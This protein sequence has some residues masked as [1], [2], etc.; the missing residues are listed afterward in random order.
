LGIYVRNKSI[1]QK[2]IVVPVFPEPLLTIFKIWKESKGALTD[3]WV[4]KT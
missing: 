4:K 2:E 3:E 1:W